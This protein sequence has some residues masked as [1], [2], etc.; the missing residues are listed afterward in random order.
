ML[1]THATVLVSM[2]SSFTNVLVWV[3]THIQHRLDRQK[4]IVFPY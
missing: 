4:L 2:S 1:S 3:S